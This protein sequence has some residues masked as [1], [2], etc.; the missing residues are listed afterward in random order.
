MG[1]GGARGKISLRF[2]VQSAFATLTNS[3]FKGFVEGAIYTGDSKAFCLPGLN[4]Y[5]CPGALGACPVG[6][7]QA[8]LSSRGKNFSFYVVGYLMLAGA[9]LGRL[10]CGF[11]CPFGLLQDITYK[12][13]F[14]RKIK[15]LP[16]ERV[17]RLLKY[18]ILVVF[19]IVLPMTVL[20]IVGQGLPWFCKYICPSGTFMAGLPL[21]FTNEG[22]RGAAGDLFVFKL[23]LLFIT[24]M[25][26]VI[27][28]RPFCRYICPLG[29]IY[30]LFNGVSLYR[31]IVDKD[32]CTSCGRCQRA[33]GLDIAVYK[34]PNSPECIRCARCKGVCPHGAVK[35]GFM[36][37]GTVSELF[38]KPGEAQGL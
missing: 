5:S 10:I 17:L 37:G 19:V 27:I 33:C 36:P 1:K 32:K 7:L 29:A 23:S 12:I 18:F 4:C 13:P 35:S 14:I 9:L 22:I 31:Y 28:Y 21:Y 20:D 8:V 25:L 16:G 11:F 38:N 2:M 3:Y 6:S 24:L 26:A 15:R 30:G 34:T